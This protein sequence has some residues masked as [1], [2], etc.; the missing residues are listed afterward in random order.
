[1]THGSEKEAR[2]FSHSTPTKT[3]RLTLESKRRT[4]RKSDCTRM[5]PATPSQ[6]RTCRRDLNLRIARFLESLASCSFVRR[7]GAPF[8]SKSVGSTCPPLLCRRLC[9]E[10]PGAELRAAAGPGRDIL[11][12][13]GSKQRLGWR[14]SRITKCQARSRR[15]NS[16]QSLHSFIHLW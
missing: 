16:K 2:L 1:M 13:S 6:A 5:N 12:A 10:K 4:L 8:R 9:S 14:L 3:H 7:P 11:G 15:S